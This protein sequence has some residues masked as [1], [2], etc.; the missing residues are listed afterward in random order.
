MGVAPPRIE[1]EGLRRGPV[2]SSAPRLHSAP[3]PGLGGEAAGDIPPR[4]GVGEGLD[5]RSCNGKTAMISYVGA[6]GG[7][8]MWPRRHPAF[9]R[10]AQLAC[11][12]SILPPLVPLSHPL[13]TGLPFSL[14]AGL[15]LVCAALVQL[16]SRPTSLLR[17]ST[18][19]P[20]RRREKE[21]NEVFPSPIPLSTFF[22][23]AFGSY[24][25]PLR[26]TVLCRFADFLRQPTT[27]T[28]LRTGRS[29]ILATISEVLG[30]IPFFIRRFPHPAI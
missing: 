22:N 1:R 6:R 27:P 12:P 10:V 3:R 2:T 17:A 4:H 15:Y 13:L 26:L 28:L 16:L 20:G 9:A 19:P 23:S 8:L 30:P 18:E 7:V 21:L 24:T 25:F 29:Y 5:S 14:P 11:L